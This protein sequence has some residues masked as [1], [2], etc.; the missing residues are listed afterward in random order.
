MK[1]LV[2][3]DG[4]QES[5]NAVHYVEKCVNFVFVLKTLLFE[6]RKTKIEFFLWFVSLVA[7]K[8]GDDKDTIVIFSAYYRT[9]KSPQ[10]E[11]GGLG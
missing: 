1:Y 4:S 10:F 11:P 7:K 8:S 3:F 2:C 5:H 6:I 9:Y